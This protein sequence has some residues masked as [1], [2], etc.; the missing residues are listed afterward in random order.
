MKGLVILFFLTALLR[1]DAQAQASAA[2]RAPSPAE[3][4]AAE[5]RGSRPEITY[6]ILFEDSNAVQAS[7]PA[8]RYT[9][10]KMDLDDDLAEKVILFSWKQLRLSQLGPKEPLLPQQ[11]INFA[12]GLGVLVIKSA[13]VGATIELNRNVIEE[14]TNAVR[15]PTPGAYRVRLSMRGYEPVEEECIVT[16]GKKTEINQRLKPVK[17]K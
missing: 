3:M 2:S 4:A 17:K 14:A 10:T 16:K 13:P 9:Y 11:L 15:F 5:I 7:L 6:D 12:S 1:A 8:I